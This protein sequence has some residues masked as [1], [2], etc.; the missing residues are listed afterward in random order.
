MAALGNIMLSFLS[1]VLVVE[2]MVREFT[3]SGKHPV[4][5]VIP[6]SN[7]LDHRAA[8]RTRINGASGA[9]YKGFNAFNQ[10]VAAWNFAVHN[11]VF[12]V[13][14]WQ[15]L[16]QGDPASAPLSS[17]PLPWTSAS[18]NRIQYPNPSILLEAQPPPVTQVPPLLLST[19]K[20]KQTTTS[21]AIYYV[22]VKGTFPGVY[23]NM[24]VFF[25]CS[26]SVLKS[27][28]IQPPGIQ[29][30]GCGLGDVEK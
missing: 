21:Q 1:P 15:M 16:P 6:T 3:R 27:V 8:V 28:T 12:C 4:V 26:E 14:P 29:S 22:V 13:P 25:L 19:P 9:A 20:R 5:A 24:Y 18:G 7:R 2:L 23:N 30:C 10:A 17:H 11:S